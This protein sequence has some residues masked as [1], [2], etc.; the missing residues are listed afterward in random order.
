MDAKKRRSK[1]V[2]VRPGETIDVTATGTATI[3]LIFPQW[4]KIRVI[5][6]KSGLPEESR[7]T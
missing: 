7:H 3:R 4:V 6:K 2:T 5:K 1:A